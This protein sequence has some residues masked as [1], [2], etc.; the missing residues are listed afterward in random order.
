MIAWTE[1]KKH[2]FSFSLLFV[3]LMVAVILYLY[4]GFD[5]HLQ[6]RV[7]YSTGAFYFLWSLIHHYQKGDLSLSLVLEYLMVALFAA[8]VMAGTLL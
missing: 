3:A 2:P 4:F 8:I 6:R 1:F 5:T 7:I